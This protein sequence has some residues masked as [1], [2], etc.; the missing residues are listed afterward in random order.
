MCQPIAEILNLPIQ[1]NEISF[2]NAFTYSNGPLCL[3]VQ[4]ERHDTYTRVSMFMEWIEKTIL[5]CG[6][7]DT[8]GYIL[9][10]NFTSE[11]DAGFQ[12]GE[13]R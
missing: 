10:N 4:A 3:F 9:E 2:A 8:C 6:G 5:Q 7:M 12:N 1:P 11:N 13:D